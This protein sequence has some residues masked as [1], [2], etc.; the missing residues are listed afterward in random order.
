MSI[1]SERYK[2]MGSGTLNTIEVSSVD[3]Y[4]K[5]IEASGGKA[6][7]AKMPIPGIGYM[8][9]CKDTEE[10]TFGI[11]QNDPNAKAADI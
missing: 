7:T 11:M 3:E 4:I 2:I 10:N 5:K 9:W 6:I 1:R 8:A